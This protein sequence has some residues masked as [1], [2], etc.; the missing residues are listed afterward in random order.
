MR[1][2]VPRISRAFR[3]LK[4]A[5]VERINQHREHATYWHR[6]ATPCRNLLL[7]EPCFEFS[8]AP[9]LSCFVKHLSD[10]VRTV[11]VGDNVCHA[12]E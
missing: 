11:G 5:V 2:F 9:A 6:P 10:D 12:T 3:I 8:T 7:I 1:A 4:L